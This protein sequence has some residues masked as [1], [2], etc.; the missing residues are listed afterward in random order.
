MVEGTARSSQGS[1]GG[2]VTLNQGNRVLLMHPLVGMEATQ[3]MAGDRGMTGQD[4]KAVVYNMLAGSEPVPSA[5]Q[6]FSKVILMRAI[7]S[8]TRLVIWV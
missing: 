8:G 4:A 1:Q 3:A 5:M 6:G 2:A 7:G